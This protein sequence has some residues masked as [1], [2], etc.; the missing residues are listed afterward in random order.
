M[1]PFLGVD[2]TENKNNE[3]FNGEE[4]LR[5][6][7]SETQLQ[8]FEKAAESGL[9]LEAKAKLPLPLRIIG[10][11][12]G[13][14]GLIGLAVIVNLWGESEEATFAHIYETLPW[15]FWL[16]GVC[17][18][19]WGVLKLLGKKKAKDTIESDEGNLTKSRIDTAVNTIYA[20]MGVPKTTPE[21]DIFAFGYKVKDGEVI[22]KTRGFEI[23]PYNNLIYRV[24]TDKDNLCLVNMEGRYEFPLSELKAIR[25]VKKS[26]VIPDWNKEESPKKGIYK[27]YKLSVDNQNCVHIKPYHIL[28]FEHNGETWGIYFPCYE[29]P[30]FEK[31]TGLKAEI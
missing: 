4:F 3:R 30:T 21:T 7:T 18:A 12:C 28:E 24:F 14:V 17:L 31:L 20:E 11:I 6:K 9:E 5:I 19:V 13:F 22:A 26:I 23:T 1:K 10:G 8:S 15:V 16:C 29:L 2:L 27:Q 25:T